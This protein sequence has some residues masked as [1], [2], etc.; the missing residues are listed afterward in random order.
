MAGLEEQIRGRRQVLEGLVRHQGHPAQQGH[1]RRKLAL[2]DPHFG[3]PQEIR[4]REV[5]RFELARVGEFQQ[6]AGIRSIPGC[7]ERGRAF[8]QRARRRRVFRLAA[9]PFEMRPQPPR[10]GGR[11]DFESGDSRS[12][13][14]PRIERRLRPR[15][16]L[17]I[18]QE[19]DPAQLP[20]P[21]SLPGVLMLRAGRGCPR[22][23]V[24]ENALVENLAPGVV[25]QFRIERRA[26][27]AQRI[28]RGAAEVDDPGHS[29]GRSRC[30]R[31]GAFEQRLH[32]IV[33]V[34]LDVKPQYAIGL[35]AHL[36]QQLV[37]GDV[38]EGHGQ[39]RPEA[40]RDAVVLQFTERGEGL[41]PVR[42]GLLA[43]ARVPADRGHLVV[44][45][46]AFRVELDH[47]RV[48]GKRARGVAIVAIEIGEHG[49][50][51]GASR[52]ALDQAGQEILG[53]AAL[54]QRREFAVGRAVVEPVAAGQLL[55][56]VEASAEA[57]AD[58]GVADRLGKRGPHLGGGVRIVDS[59]E[60]GV[61][62]GPN[63]RKRA[64]TGADRFERQLGVATRD[65]RIRG[66]VRLFARTRL[67]DQSPGRVNGQ[68]L[69][70]ALRLLAAQ[71]RARLVKRQHAQ[72]RARIAAGPIRLRRLI[73]QPVP[74]LIVGARLPVG[75]QL[76]TQLVI[77]H[78]LALDLDQA[79]LLL[80]RTRIA[81]FRHHRL[82]A[83]FRFEM[84][85]PATLRQWHQLPGRNR[86]LLLLQGRLE[87]G[88]L[89]GR[90]I[91]RHD[92]AHGVEGLGES[93]VIE[94]S[95]GP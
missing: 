50:G 4:G 14:R 24:F 67:A 60:P 45:V 64:T 38:V 26:K 62:P 1:R 48:I 55:G 87:G 27:N 30:G 74:V 16:L 52:R 73:E 59:G 32:A 28:G 61:G 34:A 81:G 20:L 39:I 21:Q 72:L 17:R 36:A 19:R 3:Q 33:A 54:R 35:G 29:L 41:P 63:A 90:V 92:L 7:L 86:G 75:L 82:E 9:V 93:V 18:E 5:V 51:I 53:V 78:A 95:A 89:L 22:R 47:V 25:E 15:G 76:D 13:S 42:D 23:R 79:A 68:Q 85:Q 12:L 71:A 65:R 94:R 58:G 56:P 88:L 2:L 69:E 91:A 6:P 40:L 49:I 10:L 57:L 8:E 31:H 83:P 37:A 11:P 77:V 80:L 43:L 66:F 44:D 46:A 70:I 84:R